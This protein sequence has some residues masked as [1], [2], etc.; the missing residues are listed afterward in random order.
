MKWHHISTSAYSII[1]DQSFTEGHVTDALK[2]RGDV[3]NLATHEQT[4]CKL[5]QEG[6]S[7]P[8]SFLVMTGNGRI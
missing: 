5:I 8:L 3:C 7:F 2:L 1:L 6:S 4:D